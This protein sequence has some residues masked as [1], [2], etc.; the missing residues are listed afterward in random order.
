MLHDVLQHQVV[1]KFCCQGSDPVEVG[2]AGGENSLLNIVASRDF[3]Q[4]FK[5]GINLLDCKNILIYSFLALPRT[6]LIDSTSYE[7]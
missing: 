5:I 2:G 6:D 7:I 1:T 4:T 3:L